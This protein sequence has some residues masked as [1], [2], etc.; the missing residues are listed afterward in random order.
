[1]CIRDSDDI[2]MGQAKKLLAKSVS[3]VNDTL[4]GR[5]YLV[6]D[7]SGADIML[8]HSLYMANR[9]ECVSDELHYLKLYIQRVASRPAFEKAINS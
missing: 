4:E 9:L 3:P 5:E 8:G 6:G 1:M 7:F 2:V